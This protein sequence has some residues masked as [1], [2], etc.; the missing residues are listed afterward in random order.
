M[1]RR[2]ERGRLGGLDFPLFSVV[3]L[4]DRLH[5]VC[6]NNCPVELNAYLYF[7]V[8]SHN[9]MNKCIAASITSVASIS[10]TVCI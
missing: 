6:H 10:G 9:T 2:I 5:V 3:A 4:H 1:Q 8:R 7:I